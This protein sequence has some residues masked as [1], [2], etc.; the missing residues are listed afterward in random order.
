MPYNPGTEYRG[1]RYLYAGL[2][3]LGRSISG[4]LQERDRRA[5]DAGLRRQEQVQRDLEAAAADAKKAKA[6]RTF[7]SAYA[8]DQAKRWESM[9]LAELEGNMKAMAAQQVDQERAAKLEAMTLN[10]AAVRDAAKRRAAVEQATQGFLADLVKFSGMAG[11]EPQM[12]LEQGLRSL[13]QQPGGAG[14]AALMRNPGA[15]QGLRDAVV[16]GSIGKGAWRPEVLQLEDGT[17]GIMVAPNEFRPITPQNQEPTVTV[18]SPLGTGVN[19]GEVSRRMTAEQWA[20]EQQAQEA[21]KNAPTIAAKRRRLSELRAKADNGN[22]YVGPE[23]M[24]MMDRRAE[25]QRLEDE[26]RAMGVDPGTA[27][28]LGV[29]E[30][31]KVGGVTVTRTR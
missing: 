29:G 16:A 21:D 7:L 10:N 20:E 1:D 25:I 17:K 5:Y 12:E 22:R 14:L 11:D 24:G 13:L 8:P 2:A 27:A 23:W 4:A 18:K 28:G 15:E 30:A 19:A 26:L 3:E 6:A 31:R 9:G